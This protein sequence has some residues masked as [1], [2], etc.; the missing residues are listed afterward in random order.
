M[1][2]IYSYCIPFFFCYSIFFLSIY[3]MT[4]YVFS[5]MPSS[6]VLWMVFVRWKFVTVFVFM[7]QTKILD[8]HQKRLSEV[9]L[10]STKI[11]CFEP[12]IRKKNAYRC[13]PHFSNIK[14]GI[15]GRSLPGLVNI[16]QGPKGTILS[17]NF[18]RMCK[19][20]TSFL[21]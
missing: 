1:H 17:K 7:V 20:W 3:I 10:T 15:R 8:T 2:L 11:N 18:R 6:I 5:L 9:I 4:T 14:C 16:M 21:E 13:K 19:I 12:K